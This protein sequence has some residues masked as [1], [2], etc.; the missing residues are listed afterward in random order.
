MASRRTSP[1]ELV[2][3]PLLLGPDVLFSPDYHA[4]SR[5]NLRDATISSRI[6]TK[7]NQ[8]CR[9]S[10]QLDEMQSIVSHKSW[11]PNTL[12][13]NRTLRTRGDCVQRVHPQRSEDRF[14]QFE[15][16]AC[17][18]MTEERNEGKK[19]QQ[20]KGRKCRNVLWSIGG[21]SRMKSRTPASE[22]NTHIIAAVR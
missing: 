12:A 1:S 7:N 19:Q 22:R 10:T 16:D 2:I 6:M 21:Y 14:S 17:D 18:P 3:C 9:Q 4:G 8:N 11:S 5:L 20:I 13:V 15:I